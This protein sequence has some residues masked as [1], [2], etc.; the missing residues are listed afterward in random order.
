M[1]ASVPAFALF[2][3]LST[4]LVGQYSLGGQIPTGKAAI[5]QANYP[6]QPGVLSI[7]VSN[8]NV[9]DGTQ[10]A[11]ILSDCPWYGPVAYLTVTG[12]RASQSTTLAGNCQVGRLS[13]IDVIYN[14]LILLKGGNPWKI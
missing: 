11:V 9:P 1:L 13:R 14:S 4:T 2:A 6:S 12:K 3:K 8:V 7:S 5:N 10:L